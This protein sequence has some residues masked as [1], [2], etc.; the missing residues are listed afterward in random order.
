MIVVISNSR[1]ARWLNKSKYALSSR[2][3]AALK[4]NHDQRNEIDVGGDKRR[5]NINGELVRYELIPMSWI[6]MS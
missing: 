1:E 5:W 2:K 3:G 4:C 6:G